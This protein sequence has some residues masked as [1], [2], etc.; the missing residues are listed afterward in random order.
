VNDVP[1]GSVVWVSLAT[2]GWFPV[3]AGSF[4]LG[5]VREW[6]AQHGVFGNGYQ[7]TSPEGHFYGPVGAITAVVV[8]R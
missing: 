6:G 8:R 7:F 2:F 5:P 1:F 4:E 3:I